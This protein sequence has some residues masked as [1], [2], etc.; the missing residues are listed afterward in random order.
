MQEKRI[1]S[2]RYKHILGS[3][4]YKCTGDTVTWI[5]LNQIFNVNRT[6]NIAQYIVKMCHICAEKKCFYSYFLFIYLFTNVD[7][8]KFLS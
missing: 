3:S 7:R 1:L 6:G 2:A 4:S 5:V 8:D